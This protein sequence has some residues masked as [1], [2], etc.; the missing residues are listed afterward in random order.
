MPPRCGLVRAA[1][2]DGWAA[3]VM[4]DPNSACTLLEGHRPRWT[5]IEKR[6]DRWRVPP[7]LR[8]YERTRATFSWDEARRRLDGLPGG[9]GLNIAHEAVD[10]HAA[11]PL[12][13]RVALRWIGRTGERRDLTYAER[14]LPW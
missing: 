4:P 5:A 12:G 9:R 8:D 7:N 2:A 6:P 14:H 3:A 11:G 1:L 13:G 10:R